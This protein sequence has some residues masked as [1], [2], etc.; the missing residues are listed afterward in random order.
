MD[1]LSHLHE[2]AVFA[3]VVEAR[4]F[5]AAARELRLSK[6]AVSKQVSRLEEALGVRLL[7]RST[8]TLSLTEAGSAVFQHCARLVA[9]AQEAERTAGNL[10]AAPRG[11][12]RLSASVTFGTR[13][14]APAIPAFIARYPEMRIELVLL[15]RFVDLAEEGFDLVVRLTGRPPEGLVARRLL[16]IE[17]RVCASPA[18]LARHGTP[19]RPAELANHNCLLYGHEGFGNLWRFRAA[20]TQAAVKVG[21]N[22][23]VN[24]NEAV[25]AALLADLG[26]GLLPQLTVAEDLAAGTLQGVL[27]KWQPI[28]PFAAAYAIYA[29]SR[30]PAPKLRAF[31][32][33]LVAHFASSGARPK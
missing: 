10:S 31:L 23:Q 19:R 13:H 2:M 25:R 6:S 21:G 18:Y 3:R 32:D 15:D 5:S 22:Y 33:H 1:P 29:P 27:P 28:A 9:A 16:D 7:H 11:T 8:R 26:I 17:F 24:S 20:G 12:L 14:I 30:L 4:G